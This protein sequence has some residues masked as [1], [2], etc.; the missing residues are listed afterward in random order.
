MTRKE[1]PEDG[2]QRE[3]QLQNVSLYQLFNLCLG[4]F[5]MERWSFY[6]DKLFML[7]HVLKYIYIFF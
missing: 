1:D 7:L 3:K 6:H 5:I 4:V 2:K